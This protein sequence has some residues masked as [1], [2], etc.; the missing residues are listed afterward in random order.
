MKEI[1]IVRIWITAIFVFPCF[2]IIKIA[3]SVEIS[4]SRKDKCYS[5]VLSVI[6]P[7]TDQ[8]SCMNR[9]ES[10]KKISLSHLFIPAHDFSW[11]RLY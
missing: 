1:Q 10:T 6:A 9:L 11:I 4:C 5:S 3:D 2:V 7:G 8:E